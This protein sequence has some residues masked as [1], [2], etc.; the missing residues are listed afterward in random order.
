MQKK[1]MEQGDDTVEKIDWKY[2]DAKDVIFSEDGSIP[3][4]EKKIY[5]TELIRLKLLRDK[6]FFIN[7]FM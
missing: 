5:S 1:R 7:E 3:N 6:P 2:F 4:E